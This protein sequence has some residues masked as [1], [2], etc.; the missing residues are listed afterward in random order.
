MKAEWV[1]PWSKANP[2]I[3]YADKACHPMNRYQ[4]VAWLVD[5]TVGGGT[6]WG[7]PPPPRVG[8]Q[9]VMVDIGV[10][11]R[12]QKPRERAQRAG[13]GVIVV[14]LFDGV[15]G[16]LLA[17]RRAGIPVAEYWR[18]ENDQWCNVAMEE[19]EVVKNC[20]VMDVTRIKGDEVGDK[21]PVWAMVDLFV[22]GF[23]CQGVSRANV[24]G[25]GLLDKRSA[26]FFDGVRIWRAI[27]AANP[28]AQ[29]LVECV[30][31]WNKRA[32]FEFACTFLAME[33][34]VT[35]SSRHSY[36]RR[37]RTYWATWQ[38]LQPPRTRAEA[39]DILDEGRVAVDGDGQRT[40]KLATLMVHSTSW[41]TGNP[42]WDETT[43][44]FD[45]LRVHEAERSM[46]MPEG[47]TAGHGRVP[48]AE[49]LKMVGNS[50]N[51]RTV[52][53]LLSQ[54]QGAIS[55]R[56]RMTMEGGGH[57]RQNG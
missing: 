30:A 17:L 43:Q 26:L 1:C 47:H 20:G 7:A 42:V 53:A 36:C 25:A 2:V 9:P 29:A 45:D 3:R 56:V 16:A 21:W 57:Q 37:E 11:K 48:A 4:F 6:Q 50:F 27:K 19:D 15:E 40:G 32:H 28:G 34:I 22:M 33:H 39:D 49:R 18:V 51:I 10:N 24:R 14:S 38:L 23:P 41:N 46:E 54:G 5:F 55:K 12:T 13:Q 31:K 8:N 44:W 52:A 35:C